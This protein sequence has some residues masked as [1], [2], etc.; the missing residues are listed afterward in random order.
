MV[1]S[2]DSSTTLL[3]PQGDVE[4]EAKTTACPLIAMAPWWSTGEASRWNCP[5]GATLT[6]WQTPRAQPLEMPQG[7]SNCL[8][9]YPSRWNCP[10]GA[11]LT[12]PQ[13]I[14]FAAKTKGSVGTIHF[15]SSTWTRS[16]SA[17]DHHLGDP[18]QLA[19][20]KQTPPQGCGGREK[21]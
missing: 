1:L 18:I 19:C 16:D 17:V 15:K 6:A 12:A 10:E 21:F 3:I 8:A 2:S 20:A 11:T 14:G 7:T 5:A 4:G 13:T 9:L